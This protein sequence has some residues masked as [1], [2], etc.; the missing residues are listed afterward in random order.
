MSAAHEGL[1]P[2]IAAILACAHAV[3][4]P[5]RAAAARR[6]AADCTA[7]ETLCEAA[8]RHGMLA[9]LHR[10]VS[11]D[12]RAVYHEGVRERLASLDRTAAER[13]L[14]QAA[15]LLRVVAHLEVHGIEALPVKGPVLAELLYGDVTLRSSRD[16]D[17]VVRYE[18]AAAARDALRELGL[19]EGHVFAEQFLRRGT[20]T[21][22]ELTLH[23]PDRDLIVDVH[24]QI[25]VGYSGGVLSGARLL[26]AAEG[27]SILGRGIRV[28]S[29]ADTLLIAC[30]HGARHHWAN[31]ED[32]LALALLVKKTEPRAWAE[33]LA[34]AGEAGG[35]RRAEVAIAHACR[36][37]GL[38]E[39]VEV[40]A[41]THR[42]PVDRALL[43][44]LV[45]RDLETPGDM[46]FHQSLGEMVWDFA[47][48][49]SPGA[50]A[51]HAAVRLLRPGVED[52]DP[53][54]PGHGTRALDYVR[55]PL[56]LV[57]KWGRRLGRRVTSIA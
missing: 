24:W 42:S 11:G 35:R 19:V 9:H 41:A 2:E 40:A 4:D 50:A 51:R 53:D 16:L 21:E 30:L 49:D 5:G 20:H 14:R 28:P 39:P 7:P 38:P 37:F 29:P 27:G 52:W 13:S 6:A 45:P 48:E 3:V 18:Q 12:V 26:A 47:A 17:L 33:T 25:G 36:V 1:S 23:A 57:R 31:V 22:G 56:R 54:R 44:A 8:V 15:R 46:R 32:L 10:L 34:R 55:R 43:G